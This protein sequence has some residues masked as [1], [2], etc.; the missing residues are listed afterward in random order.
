[1][2]NFKNVLAVVLFLMGATLF[3]QT[4]LTGKVVD[5]SSQPLPGAD[6]IVK[7]TTQGTSSDFDGNF[8]LETTNNSG[9][10]TIS[11]IGFNSRTLEFNGSKDFGTVQLQ[12]S[13]ESLDEVVIVGV[14]DIAKDR[15]TPVAVSTIKAAEIVERLGS[16][17][18]PEILKATPSVYATKQGGGFGDARINIRGFDQRNTAVMING[19]PVN[20]ME[21]GWVYWSNW[22]G[23][24]DV[25]SA[26]QVQRGLGSSKLAISSVGG[27]INVLTRTSDS[28]EG[29]NV[30][31]YYGNDNYQKYLAS[32]STG[33]MDSGFS[34]TILLGRTTGDGFK[35]GQQFEGYNYFLG[36]GYQKGKSSLQLTVTG[37]PQW[38]HQLDYAP[39]IETYLEYGEDGKPSNTYNSDW[40]YQNGE[41]WSWER[42]FYHKPIA[43]LNWDLNIS[44][45]SKINSVLYASVG[46][47]GGTGEI[48]RINGNRAYSSTFK[49]SD[50]IYRNDDIY[51]WNIGQ[52]VPDFANPDY[53]QPTMRTLFN[54]HFYNTGNDGHPDGEG[55][56]GSDNG[57]TRRASMN[58]HN[59]YGIIANFNTELNENLTFDFGVDGRSYTGIHYRR[60]ES[61]L[62]ADG[63]IDYDNMNNDNS[64]LTPSGGVLVTE[65][66]PADIS[67]MLNVFGKVDDEQKIDYHNDGNVNWYGAF[68]QLEY[69]KDAITAFIQGGV[70][71]QGFRRIDYFNYLDSDPEQTSDWQNIIGGNVKGGINWNATEH[72]K[73][74]A[75][76]G[77][78]SKQPLFDAVFPN[79]TNNDVNEGLIN[80]TVIGTEVGYGYRSENYRVDINLYRTSWAD[81]FLRASADFDLTPLNEEDEDV[82]GV[83]NLEGVTQIHQGVEIEASARFDKLRVNVMGG[84]GDFEYD[85]DV[86][87]KYFDDN[88]NEIIL[89]GESE[90]EE[91]TL[92]LKGKKVGDVA[93]IT[94]RLGLTYNIL[95]DLS[96]DVSQSYVDKLYAR[97]DAPAFSDEDHPGS[98]EL[99]SFSL[100]NA[101]LSYKLK[102]A[103]SKY[104][105]KFRVNVNNVMNHL[106][107]SDSDT[108]DHAEEGDATWNGVNTSNRVYFGYG[109]TWN[110]SLRFAF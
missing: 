66:Y 84:I 6:V 60:I 44:D 13:S 65:E 104:A 20:D 109:R 61:L 9:T 43:S 51:D 17:E 54:G 58:S 41:E 46:R 47:G 22:A 18:F 89:P 7:G 38:H 12:A 99:P 91:K 75:N 14:A 59:W 29:G 32:Y 35:D 107:I 95:D 10:I 105:L 98:L 81:R 19:M 30:G 77:Y 94:A 101:G 4:N 97:I 83:A 21:N 27:T 110:A 23:L 87:A 64:A 79:Y 48:G 100:M 1:M 36:F 68:T 15:K 71:Q 53:N 39:S 73:F 11:F 102:F 88:E 92:Y 63:Y 85:S 40:G 28:K 5:D 82:R 26:M 34:S 69:S 72:S 25:T 80:E 86:T 108:N 50:G 96:I 93:H 3:A 8:N 56:Y 67:A 24:S 2:K 33:L 55:K 37:A 31:F 78:Y 57:L 52:S 49:N 106:Y 45:R 74:F 16:Q 70:S 76:A 90:A 42:N 62:G 103:D